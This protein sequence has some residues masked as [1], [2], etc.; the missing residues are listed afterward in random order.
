MKKNGFVFVESI[1][2]LVVVALSLAML[3]SSYSLVT[4]KTKEKEYYD[5]ASDKYLL[6][7]LSNIGTDGLCNYNIDCSS[8]LTGVTTSTYKNT[9]DRITF[10]ADATDDD[11]YSCSKTKIGA[12]IY[13]CEQVFKEMSLVHLYVVKDILND[14][15]P[16][17]QSGVKNAIDFFDN[18]TIEYMKSLKKCNDLDFNKNSI[19]CENPIIYLIG[20]FERSNGEYHYASI[21]LTSDY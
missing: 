17:S 21:S 7:S 20:V 5:K 10:R 6:Y 18:G 13:D 9:S 14:L 3:I 4:R 16:T 19:S 8:T 2:V 11:G 15:K 1:V 12:L